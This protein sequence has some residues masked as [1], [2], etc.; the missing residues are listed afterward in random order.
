M[1]PHDIVA[2]IAEARGYD[3]I[4]V[5]HAWEDWEAVRLTLTF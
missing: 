4:R 5:E 2:Q 3:D 1:V